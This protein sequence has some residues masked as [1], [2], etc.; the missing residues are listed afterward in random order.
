[1][2]LIA[3]GA[4]QE[5]DPPN[6]LFIIVDDLRPSIGAYGDPVAYTPHIDQLASRGFVFKN[7]FASVPVCGASRA[8]L[9]SGRRPT[10]NRFLEYNSRMDVDLPGEPGLPEHFKDNGYLTIANGKVFD[11]TRDSE[12][13]W[14]EP[15]WN[16]ASEWNSPIQRNERLVDLQKA[17]LENPDG[18]LGPPFERLDVEDTDYPD[19]RIAEKTVRDL[20]RLKKLRM[21]F[22]LAVGFRKPHLPFNAPASYWE[23]YNPETFVLPSTFSNPP[24]GAPV[25]AIHNSLELRT[26]YSGVPAEGLLGDSDALQLIHAYYAAVS[27]VDAQIGKVLTALESNGLADDTIVILI[28]DHGWSLG[29]HTMWTKHNLFDITLRSPMILRIPNLDGSIV[30]GIT[31]FLD[32]FPTLT[33]LTGLQ[34]PER[35]DGASI[36]PMFKDPKGVGKLASFSRWQ[37]GESVRTESFRYTEWR[38][39]QGDVNARMLYDLRIDPE[40]TRNVAEEIN[41]KDAVRRLSKLIK[42]KNSDVTVTH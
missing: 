16:P 21:P 27:Y 10:A 5:T 42:D 41:Y 25:N 36:V 31:D 3:C 2:L 23:H 15:V 32:I 7:A 1:M 37:N 38:D 12:G 19:G 28:G 4:P 29:E 17:Y 6:V 35:L 26:Q 9:L 11:N 24:E 22:F 14:S 13:S 18:E 33:D 34:A 20:E 30:D 40:E 39:E 8:S